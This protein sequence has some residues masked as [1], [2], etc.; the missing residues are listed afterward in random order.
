MPASSEMA[1]IFYGTLLAV[2]S[3]GQASPYAL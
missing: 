2:A 3:A 1:G